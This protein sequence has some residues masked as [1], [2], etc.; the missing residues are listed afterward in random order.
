MADVLFISPAEMTATTILGGNVDIEKYTVNVAFVQVMIIEPLL[1]SELYDKIISDRAGAGLAGAYLTLF[2][3][4]VVPIT[5]HE[6]LAEYLE[7]SNLMVEQ[8]GTF[9]HT[10]EHRQVPTKDDLFSLSGKYHAMAQAYIER[11]EKWICKNITSVPEYKRLQDEVNAQH[12]QATSG[13][14]FGRHQHNNSTKRLNAS[15]YLYS[16][17]INEQ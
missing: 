11:F 14:Y 17:I 13:M 9:I 3:E 12:I 16:D 8:G 15:D 1:G 10:A 5:K 7:V 6:G 4:F 2:N